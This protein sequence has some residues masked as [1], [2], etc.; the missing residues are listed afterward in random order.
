MLKLEASFPVPDCRPHAQRPSSCLAVCCPNKRCKC[1]V[2]C[3]LLNYPN[4]PTTATATVEFFGKAIEF[5]HRHNLLL[6]HDNPYVDM[7]MNESL[8]PVDW[9]GLCTVTN[10]P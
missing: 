9:F 3:V 6:I 1:R 5:C 7:V 2:K 4:N 8:V 10:L